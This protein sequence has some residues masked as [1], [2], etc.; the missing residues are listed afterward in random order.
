MATIHFMHYTFCRIHR[1]L[2]VGPAME[3][4]LTE[5]QVIGHEVARMAPL[6]WTLLVRRAHTNSVSWVIL[7]SIYAFLAGVGFTVLLGP[8]PMPRIPLCQ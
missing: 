2:L 4:K 5:S 7:T 8:F 3:A 1:T 6:N